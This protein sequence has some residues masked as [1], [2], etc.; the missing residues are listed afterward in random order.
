MTC[1][2]TLRLV[3]KLEQVTLDS[4]VSVSGKAAGMTG[5]SACL[6][7]GDRITIWDLLHGLML[8]SGNDAAWALAEYFSNELENSD[9]VKPFL[10][11]MNALAQELGLMNTYYQNPHGLSYQRNL[12]TA[13]EV[14]RLTKVALNDSRFAC[15]VGTKVHTCSISGPNARRKQWENTNKLLDKGFDGVKTGVTNAA[16]PCLCASVT[17]GGNRVIVVVLSAKS[18][19]HRWVEVPKLADWAFNRLDR[20]PATDTTKDRSQQQPQKD[21]RL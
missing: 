13:R 3:D 21:W 4:F 9:G 8:P 7:E 12:S 20:R 17:R 2:A 15:I 14:C 18:M 19:N 10:S 16:G 6:F 5:T 1:Y 11:E